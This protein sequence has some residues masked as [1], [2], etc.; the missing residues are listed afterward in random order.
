MSRDDGITLY[1]YG[2]TRSARCRWVLQELGVPFEAVEIDLGAGQHRSPEYLA[3]NP[4]GRIP[5]LVHGDLTLFESVA[6]CLHLANTFPEGGLL[7]EPGSRERAL[8]DQWLMFCTNELEQPLWRTHRHL[9]LHPVE[10]RILADVWAARA[11]FAKATDVL[12][13]TLDGR[14]HLVGDRLTVADVVL[15]YTLGWSTWYGLLADSPVLQRY[16][17]G[18]LARPACPKALSGPIDPARKARSTQRTPVPV[19][20]L[21]AVADL[22]RA[23]RFYDAAFGWR[24]RI[25]VPVLVEYGLPDG[26]GLG[27]YQREGFARNTGELPTQAPEGRTTATE[28]YLRCEDLDAAIERIE[29]AGGRLLSARAAR[30]WG[31][32]AAYYADPDGNV[33]ALA[34]PLA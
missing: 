12:A 29:A 5:A 16:L 30:D 21:L 17:A 25:D 20:T 6:I 7:P 28:L 23:G 34:R 32:E 15:G 19:M 27:V 22:E 24:R 26:R 10:R 11:E 33:L 4:F 1:E 2:P 18:L 13:A 8:H 9:R 3:I 14:Q 31:D